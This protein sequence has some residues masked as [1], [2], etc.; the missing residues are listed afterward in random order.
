MEVEEGSKSKRRSRYFK[1]ACVV[2]GAVLIGGVVYIFVSPEAGASVAGLTSKVTRVIGRAATDGVAKAGIEPHAVKAV[3]VG[4]S[5]DRVADQFV[6]GH[7]KMQACGRGWMDHRQIWV[8]PYL[9]KGA[10]AA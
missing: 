4:A 1:A 9:R 2:G 10:T 5:V 7:S 8:D 3:E 6:R